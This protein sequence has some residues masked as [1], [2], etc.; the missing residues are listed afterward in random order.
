M[1]NKEFHLIVTSQG[2]ILTLRLNSES[3]SHHHGRMHIEEFLIANA[4]FCNWAF[5][6]YMMLT[7]QGW[8]LTLMSILHMSCTSL[9]MGSSSGRPKTPA[10]SSSSPLSCPSLV[11]SSF[12]SMSPASLFRSVLS[13]SDFVF[14]K[15]NYFNIF[16]AIRL[17]ICR[18]QWI[19]LA[20]PEKWVRR[21]MSSLIITSL[22]D[23]LLHATDS[24]L[25]F[26]VCQVCCAS[27]AWVPILSPTPKLSRIWVNSAASRT[28]EWELAI[29]TMSKSRLIGITFVQNEQSWL[30]MPCYSVMSRHWL[31]S[32]IHLH[33]PV[34]SRSE[35]GPKV[36]MVWQNTCRVFA[37]QLWV[38]LKT[39]FTS[40]ATVSAEGMW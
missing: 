15:S 19:Q 29:S 2:I 6:Q 36:F 33:I 28:P 32:L 30:W 12:F 21:S 23:A 38:F 1:S 26:L 5:G 34:M 8:G 13:S 7:Q 24:T 39:H 25:S 10:S 16:W 31:W 35:L 37:I 20:N 9:L 11:S 14:N 40:R 27:T 4:T 22:G 3:T 17:M 18:K